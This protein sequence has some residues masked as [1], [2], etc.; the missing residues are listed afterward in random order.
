M[1]LLGCRGLSLQVAG[2][3]K[4]DFRGLDTHAEVVL[5]EEGE[6][7]GWGAGERHVLT[8]KGTTCEMHTQD[9]PSEFLL[10]ADTSLREFKETGCCCC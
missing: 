8:P 10:C 7:G 6:S 1:A 3:Q 9:N 5:E 2:T 4:V